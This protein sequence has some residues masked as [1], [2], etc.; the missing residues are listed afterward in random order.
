MKVDSAWGEDALAETRL[1]SAW[2]S[3]L[4]GVVR[5]NVGPE[6][7]TTAVFGPPETTLSRRQTTCVRR[8]SSSHANS[9]IL[10]RLQR[11][12]ASLAP[13]GEQQKEGRTSE[14]E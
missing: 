12:T 4:G 5:L 2:G 1:V 3:R 6:R 13:V 11:Q 14:R 10:M 8:W 9:F 7:A